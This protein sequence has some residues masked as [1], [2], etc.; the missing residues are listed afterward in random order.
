MISDLI[1]FLTVNKIESATFIGHSLG[2]MT[3]ARLASL[4]PEL[5]EKFV[6]IDIQ[7]A[8]VYRQNGQPNTVQ[9]LSRFLKKA[10]EIVRN[11]NL[12]L[13]SS[14]KRMN[15]LLEEQVKVIN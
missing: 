14:K 6:L 4:Y 8:K 10:I 11:E 15:E 13:E 9:L 7:P 1:N 3:I 2:A 12:D 5:V